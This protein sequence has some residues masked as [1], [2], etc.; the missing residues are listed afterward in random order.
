MSS[1]AK[2]RVKGAKKLNRNKSQL[3]SGETLDSNSVDSAKLSND[4][5]TYRLVLSLI[6]ICGEK[7]GDMAIRYPPHVLDLIL[8]F[9]AKSVH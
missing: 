2:D 8:E 4:E 9:L 3:G 7:A 5:N 6:D 1:N